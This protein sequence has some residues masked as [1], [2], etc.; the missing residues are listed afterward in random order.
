MKN[1]KIKFKKIIN[2]KRAQISAEMIILLAAIIAIVLL[3]VSQLQKTTK[4][5]NA[6]VEK[7]ADKVYDEIE[8]I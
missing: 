8:D 3:V 2:D 6:T 7:K 5:A 4:K 1:Y